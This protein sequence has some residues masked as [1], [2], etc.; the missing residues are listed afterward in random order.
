MN[1]QHS[2]HK[3][4]W[5]ATI[6]K[7]SKYPVGWVTAEIMRDQSNLP[8]NIIVA[9]MGVFLAGYFIN[10]LFHIGTINAA[11]TLPTMR[12]TLVGA[13]ILMVIVRLMRH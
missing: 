3:A 9:I 11:I 7:S 4:R 10:P 1:D 13:V 12:A 6:V 5:E 8:T 2:E